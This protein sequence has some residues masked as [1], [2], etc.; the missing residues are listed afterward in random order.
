M[1][2][3]Q[4]IDERLPEI[5]SELLQLAEGN[6]DEEQAT[7]FEALETEHGEL[8]TERVPLA[9]RAAFIERIRGAQTA[10]GSR[11]T[12][13]GGTDVHVRTNQGP[14]DNLDAVRSG[15]VPA[16]DLRSRALDAIEQAPDYVEDA[17]REHAT[18]MVE[19]NDRHGR[20]ARHMLMTGSDAYTRAFE[21]VLSGAQPYHLPQDEAEAMRAAMSLT[22]GNGGYLVPFHLDPTLILTNAGSTNPIRQLARV[23]RITG[24]N[25][26]GITTAGVTAEWLAEGDEA[27][28]ASPS[29]TQPDATPHK[30]AAYLQGSFEVTQDT[31][32]ASQ[33]GMLLAD[34]KDNLEANAFATGSGTG[35]P[36]GVV[37]AVAAV[38]GSVVET[39]AASTY[40]VED[41]YA[42]KGAIPARHRRNAQWLS[43][44]SIQLLTRQ[45]ATGSGPT[46][47]FWADLGMDTPSQ[48]LGRSVHE[49]SQM[50]TAVADGANILLL[51]DFSRYLIVDRIGMTVQ[52]EPLVKGANQRP[53]GEVGWFAHWR[54][55]GDVLDA[56]AFR[57]LQVQSA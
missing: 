27:A 31:G 35:Q 44:E 49:A 13:P 18:R 22:D 1:N 45:F 29:F 42:L 54:V 24:D 53:T 37:T 5:R 21:Q 41:V 55:G 19:R 10:G 7:R 28:D 3:L 8:E 36:R 25:W 11:S 47:A 57:L 50:A 40:A 4:E 46:H 15:M 39:A 17:H 16:A 38:S 32:I 43:S 26:H 23:D 20:I 12:E 52:F 33:V 6:L 56:N 2:R 14:F 48:L 30:A 34:A 51:G 9:E